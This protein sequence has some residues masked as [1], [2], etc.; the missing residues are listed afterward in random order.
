M[1]Y[2][3]FCPAPKIRAKITFQKSTFLRASPKFLSPPHSDLPLFGTDW[4]PWTLS[5]RTEGQLVLM[6]NDA[7]LIRPWI[8]F[9]IIILLFHTRTTNN[10]SF[11]SAWLV[12]EQVD[13]DADIILQQYKFCLFL[14]TIIFA[15]ILHILLFSRSRYLNIRHGI[16]FEIFKY[17]IYFRWWAFSNMKN[18]ATL[19]KWA[20][21]T[22]IS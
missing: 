20:V 15:I 4:R 13:N 18:C 6:G 1:N 7:K 10:Y 19:H 12:V 14:Y 11:I 2:H 22:Y 17:N 21:H 16:D 9:S 3:I 8:I 5:S